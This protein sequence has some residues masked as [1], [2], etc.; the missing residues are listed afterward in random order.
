[1]WKAVHTEDLVQT[2]YYRSCFCQLHDFYFGISTI[3]VDT[4]FSGGKRA[5]EVKVDLLPWA[6][7]YILAA[8]VLRREEGHR[9]QG[10]PS[11]MGRMACPSFVMVLDYWFPVAWHGMH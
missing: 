7:R 4:Y 6:G 9:S 2:W 10:G 8:S 5:I 11:A 3:T 1:M